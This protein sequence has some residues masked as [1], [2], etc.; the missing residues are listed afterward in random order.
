MILNASALTKENYF[1]R[2]DGLHTRVFLPDQILNWVRIAL[3]P[4]SPRSNP[5]L[6]LFLIAKFVDFY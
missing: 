2:L 1:R 4:L 5:V 3:Y 6:V